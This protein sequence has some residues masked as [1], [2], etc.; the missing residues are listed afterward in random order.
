MSLMMSSKGAR[1]VDREE[2]FRT[3]IIPARTST[4]CPVTNSEFV[5]MINRVS[6]EHGLSLENEKLGLAGKDLQMFGTYTVKGKDFFGGKINLVLGIANSYDKTLPAKVCWGQKVM[7][8]SNLSFFAYGDERIKSVIRHKHTN[9]V[10]NTDGLYYRLNKAMEQVD[11]F[12]REQEKFC[13]RLKE[14]SITKEEAYATIIRSARENVINKTN[15]L[16]VADNWD[17]QTENYPEDEDQ[18]ENWYSDFRSK[19]CYS[20]FNCYTEQEKKRIERNPV[21]ASLDTLKLT[22]FFNKEFVMN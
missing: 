5:E 19:D 6:I 10:L 20:L 22:E 13:E 8:C 12:V 18:Y 9:R 14:R 21:S 16:S 3:D 1:F 15:I 4:Y 7:V 17:F 11:H 2:A